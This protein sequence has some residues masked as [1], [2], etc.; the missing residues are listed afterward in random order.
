MTARTKA[1]I[2]LT[3]SALFFGAAMPIIKPAL[4][5]ISPPQ[6]LFSRYTLALIL[7]TPLLL[8]TKSLKPIPSP[9]L[10]PVILIESASIGILLMLYSGLHLTH[11]LTAALILTTRPLFTT[12]AGIIFS[13]EQETT[14]EWLGLM[15]SVAGTT[16]VILSPYSAANSPSL[17]TLNLMGIG[18]ILITNVLSALTTIQI[19]RN[20]ASLSKPT[21]TYIHLL[22][23]VIGL[24]FWLLFTHRLPTITSL[25]HPSV[26]TPV[27]YMAI[28]GSII[29]LTLQLYGYS[30][31]EASEATLFS[32]LQPL[33]Y[34]PLGV[35]WLNEVLLPTQV[36]GLIIIMIGVLLAQSPPHPRLMTRL[37]NL[38][39]SNPESP[40]PY[41]V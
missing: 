34:L 20:Y 17:S 37:R 2:A 40:Q 27:L 22:I 33:V 31:M 29:A 30:H 3:L 25:T 36:A 18:L 11:S 9:A 13:H 35:F 28:A 26:L 7:L 12:L 6:F 1:V 32:Y 4:N 10:I 21:I 39:G 24:G 23:G 19:R 16:T 38:F 8:F 15:L 14:N 41:H 5:I